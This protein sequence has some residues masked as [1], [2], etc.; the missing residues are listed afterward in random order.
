MLICIW[1]VGVTQGIPNG[2]NYRPRSLQDAKNYAKRAALQMIRDTDAIAA[3][4]QLAGR[5]KLHGGIGSG[6]L[7]C[8]DMQYGE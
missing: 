2:L 3:G 5:L 4:F 1:K 7:Y 8:L 6:S